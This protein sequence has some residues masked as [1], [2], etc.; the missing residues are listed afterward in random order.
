MGIIHKKHN[1]SLRT[2]YGD[3]IYLLIVFSLLALVTFLCIYPLWFTIIASIS[4]ANAVYTGKVKLLPHDISMEAYRLVMNNKDIWR[5]YLNT[6]FYTVVGTAF[7]LFLTI[8]CAYALS[9][10]KMFGRGFFSV[11]FVIAMYFSG[12]MIPTYILMIKLH[13]INTRWALIFT[14][15]LS[16]Y[17][18]IITRT[19]FQNSIPETI[20]EAAEIDGASEFRSFFTIALPLSKPIIA[21]I[22]LYYAVYHWS[23]YFNAMLYITNTKLQPLQIVLQQILIYN[24]TAYDVASAQDVDAAFLADLA[25]RAHLATTIKYAIVFIASAPMLVIYPFIQKF[26]VKGIMIGSLKE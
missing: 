9:K 21:V 20:Y 12:G 5:G 23:D 13:L 4:D 8:P 22:A 18:L 11:L 10:K 16:I 2:S 17:N 26:F 7:D 15:A 3:K 6:I 25:Y 1:Q 19:Y 14:G 24:K